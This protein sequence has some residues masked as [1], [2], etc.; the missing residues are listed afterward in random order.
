MKLQPS[1]SIPTCLTM[2]SRLK[3]PSRFLFLPGSRLTCRGRI[4][5]RRPETGNLI[6]CSGCRQPAAAPA[7]L[8]SPTRRYSQHCSAAPSHW[9][10]SGETSPR[11]QWRQRKH[12]L[13][14]KENQG[15]GAIFAG[16]PPLQGSDQ[17]LVPERSDESVVT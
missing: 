1:I 8:C 15:A 7:I 4:L 6:C 5:L 3:T 16:V 9:R 12:E 13:L 10:S 17:N 2:P 14:E 11:R